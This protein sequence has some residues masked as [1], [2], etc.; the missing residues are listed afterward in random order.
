M[1]AEAVK[2]FVLLG[3]PFLPDVKGL[4]ALDNRSL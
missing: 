3:F 2:R 4:I 1:L